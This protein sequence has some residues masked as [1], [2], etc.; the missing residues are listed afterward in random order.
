MTYGDE[1]GDAED[2]EGD[3]IISVV[4]RL[5]DRLLDGDGVALHL[6]AVRFTKTVYNNLNPEWHQRF[7]MG[8]SALQDVV[9]ITV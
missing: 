9:K 8:V 4:P 7:E 3:H 6:C 5:V 2:E 1:A